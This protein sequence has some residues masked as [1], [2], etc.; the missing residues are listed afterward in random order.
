MTF[1]VIKSCTSEEGYSVRFFKGSGSRRK[2]AHEFKKL[3]N[4][5]CKKEKRKKQKNT[6]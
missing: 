6:K 2:N 3:N 5:N 4:K 1:F